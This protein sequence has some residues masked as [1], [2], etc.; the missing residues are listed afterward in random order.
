MKI[1]SIFRHFAH[2]FSTKDKGLTAGEK[3]TAIAVGILLA[4]FGLLPGIAAFY[5]LTY[6]FKSRHVVKVTADPKITKVS[7]R[8]LSDA[9]AAD[10]KVQTINKLEISAENLE[11]ILEAARL[12]QSDN[13]FVECDKWIVKNK[14]TLDPAFT[15]NLARLYP[16]QELKQELINDM[17]ESCHSNNK[18]LDFIILGPLLEDLQNL[19]L[20]YN[21][22]D[23]FPH[24]IKFCT[25]P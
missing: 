22:P 16:L 6:F 19:K 21:F 4:P 2:P 5:G 7:N 8:S 13:V 1:Q 15:Y 24:I 11:G 25:Q 14:A 23:D 9:I 18:P 17:L 3:C 12:K 20:T 10:P